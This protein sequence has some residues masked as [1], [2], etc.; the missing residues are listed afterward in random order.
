VVRFGFPF[1]FLCLVEGYCT[2]LSPNQD[3]VSD[4][5][6]TGRQSCYFSIVERDVDSP[7]PQHRQIIESDHN[8][9]V[10]LDFHW[11]DGLDEGRTVIDILFFS[12]FVVAEEVTAADHIDESV[13]SKQILSVL[14]LETENFIV[15][16]NVE[17]AQLIAAQ[18]KHLIIAERTN[19]E[20][21]F[22]DG[23][24]GA[25]SLGVGNELIRI[26]LVNDCWIGDVDYCG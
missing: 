14:E 12:L 4:P 24:G 15:I 1:W 19:G 11:G 13:F 3:P 8:F 22:A 25:F 21:V 5:T 10:A 9:S 18:E 23:K 16:D 26:G 2:F 6:E 20:D 7:I 17:A